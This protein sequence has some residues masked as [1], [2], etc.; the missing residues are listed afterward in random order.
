MIR[1]DFNQAVIRAGERRSH[2]LQRQSYVPVAYKRFKAYL[3]DFTR[4]RLLDV[5]CAQGH[6]VREFIALGV[7]AEGVEINPRY[8]KAGR[9]L[10]PGIKITS[11]NAERLEQPDD[12]FDLVYCRNVVF[13]TD[14]QKS[15]PELKRV[16]RPGGIG[17][18]T[19]DK[20]IVRLN[21]HSLLHSAEIDTM[22]ALLTGCEVLAKEYHER[23]DDEPWRHRHHYYDVYFKK[24]SRHSA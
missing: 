4:P 9:L 6:E 20:K 15:L 21:D 17:H 14:P 11:G 19:L 13:S 3:T 12:Y 1:N 2:W 5:G 16:L 7:D 22:V 18:V 23:I 8:V 24:L 10:F